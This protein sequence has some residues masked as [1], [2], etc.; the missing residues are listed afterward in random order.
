MRARRNPHGRDV[1]QRC[2]TSPR[3]VGERQPPGR[4]DSTGDGGRISLV[5]SDR[6]GRR[7]VPGLPSA[8]GECKARRGTALQAVTSRVAVVRR[9]ILLSV[10]AATI[11][12]RSTLGDPG[13][14]PAR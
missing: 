11:T 7:F 6:K 4:V 8:S 5:A 3:V 1:I 13:L 2:V 9:E 10:A 12:R 14:Q